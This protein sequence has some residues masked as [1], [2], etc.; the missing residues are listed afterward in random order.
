MIV[1]ESPSGRAYRPMRPGLF[2]RWVEVETPRP[3]ALGKEIQEGRRCTQALPVRGEGFSIPPP[4]PFPASLPNYIS[5]FALPLG[6]LC[7]III[8]PFLP[9]MLLSR[10]L[11]ICFILYV[12]HK[13]RQQAYQ[14]HKSRQY[15]VRYLFDKID[16][17]RTWCMKH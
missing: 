12:S 14:F 4:L 3:P 11:S 1:R 16:W 2:R 7:P 9:C 5:S 10:L 8:L 6:P 13:C 17:L 15:I